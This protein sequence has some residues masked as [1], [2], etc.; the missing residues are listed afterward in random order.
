MATRQLNP[1][2]AETYRASSPFKLASQMQSSDAFFWHAEAATPQLRPLV[3]GLFLLDRPPDRRRFHA[4]IE[5]LIAYA[6]RLRQHV[7]ESWSPLGLPAW[8][9]DPEFDLGYHLRS[10]NLPEP[11]NRRHLFDFAS[12]LFA[13]PLDHLRPLWE[14]YLIEGLEGGGAA[15]FLKLHHSVMDGVGALA[16]FDVLTQPG[17]SHPVRMPRNE[18]GIPSPLYPAGAGANGHAGTWWSVR[19]T[20]EPLT[21]AVSDA[22]LAPRTTANGLLRTM[23]GVG[24]VIREVMTAPIQD[25]LSARCTG[26]GRR[27]DGV[28]FSLERLQRLKATLGVTLNDLVLTVVAGALRRY[29]EHRGIILKEVQ[30]MVPVNLRQ[31]SERCQLGNRVTAVSVRLPLDERDPLRRLERIH[32]RATAVKGNS[33]GAAYAFFMKAVPVIPAAALRAIVQAA[34]GRVHLICSN[35]PGPSVQRYLA[36]AK[37][38]TVHPF[39]PIMLGIPLSIALLSYGGTVGIGI[40]TDPAAIPDP[41]RL[42]GYLEEEVDDLERRV[43]SSPPQPNGGRPEARRE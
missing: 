43:L 23:T 28:V 11:A 7:V 40:D 27:L 33:Q 41:E 17:R 14:G 6:P 25:P 42:R 31:D 19:N 5:R 1:P 8:E 35:V 32:R 24:E 29:H 16:L 30:C 12:A 37:I 13:T 10:V 34:K 4:S 21:R 20:I 26:I 9:T 18:R 2:R 15:F 22:L 39:A 38:E 3:A 36:G